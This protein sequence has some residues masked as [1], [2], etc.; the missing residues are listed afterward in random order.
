LGASR[1]RF[2][3]SICNIEKFSELV[4]ATCATTAFA[5][6]AGVKIIRAHDIKENRQAIDVAYA[7]K[8]SSYK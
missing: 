2:M 6:M 3:G 1:K 7:L 4:G 5:V 8:Q